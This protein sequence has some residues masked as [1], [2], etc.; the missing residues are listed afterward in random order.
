VGIFGAAALLIAAMGIYGVVSYTVVLR[1]PEIGVR[2]ALGAQP[3]GIFRLVL[4]HGLRLVAAGL[5]A[6]L[7]A[8][9]LVLRMGSGMLFETSTAD[10]A[11]YITITALLFGVAVLA[12]YWPGRRAMAVDPLVA[13]RAE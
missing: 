8:A 2:L 5:A 6:G 10:P 3:A 11:T 12:C 9:L 7:L 1:T 4:G 13:L